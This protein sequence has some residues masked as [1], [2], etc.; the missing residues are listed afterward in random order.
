MICLNIMKFLLGSILSNSP[1]MER[2]CI[3]SAVIPK[4]QMGVLA[5]FSRYIF[6]ITDLIPHKFNVIFF[7]FFQ[8]LINDSC[9]TQNQYPNSSTPSNLVLQIT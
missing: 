9:Y 7:P 3:I 2:N 8:S 5:K 1:H 6:S 4:L